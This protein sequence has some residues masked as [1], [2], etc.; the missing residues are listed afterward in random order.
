MMQRGGDKKKKKIHVRQ[1]FGKNI[2]RIRRQRK[3]RQEQ[4]KSMAGAALHL[5][6]DKFYR[7][8][9]VHPANEE[10]LESSVTRTG[11]KMMNK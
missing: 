4:E 8:S 5:V 3:R 9:V 2:H 7:G 1:R 6:E 11:S 10:Q